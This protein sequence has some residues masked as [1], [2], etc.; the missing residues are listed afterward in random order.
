MSLRAKI[1]WLFAVF[2]VI[3]ILTVGVLDYIMYRGAYRASFQQRME[4]AVGSEMAD[5]FVVAR[6]NERLRRLL[7]QAAIVLLT[8]LAFSALLKRVMRSLGELTAAADQIGRGDFTPWL[9]PPGEDEIGRLSLAIG[10]MGEQIREML[11]QVEQGRQLAVIGEFASYL[12]HEIRNPLSSLKLNLQGV[13]RGVRA[14]ELGQHLPQLLDTCIL[15]INRLDRVVQTI[16]RLG[17]KDSSARAPCSV[18][19]VLT[20]VAEL[21]R[22]QFTRCGVSLELRELAAADEVMAS[23]EQLKG[24]FLNLFLNAADAMPDGGRL[25]VSTRNALLREREPVV[26]IH[27]VDEGRGIPPELRDTIFDPFFTTKHEGSGLGLP[28]ALRSVRHVGGD[29]RY[30]KR[31]EMERGA[32][33]VITL[34]VLAPG[35]GDHSPGQ[36]P[37][38]AAPADDLVPTG[39]WSS[40]PC[41]RRSR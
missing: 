3:P 19:R 35:A 40:D 38:Q 41:R 20:E 22:L 21:V 16:L 31:S 34:P 15:E 5:G 13:A 7:F 39:N 25:R 4:E 27:V 2:A 36:D 8:S 1:L 12:A 18:H 23:S 10:S 26:T 24:V 11:R 14:G 33:F 9:P 28:L 37:A 30:E 32:A 6:D 29:L 17:H